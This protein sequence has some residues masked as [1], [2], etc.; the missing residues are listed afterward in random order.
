MSVNINNVHRREHQ[1]LPHL[2][3]EQRVSFIIIGWCWLLWCWV[4][5]ARSGYDVES[6]F[7]ER[8][9]NVEII[10]YYLIVVLV[11]YTAQL[12]VSATSCVASYDCFSGRC[13][14]APTIPWQ[15]LLVLCNGWA[16]IVSFIIIGWCWLLWCSVVLARSCYDVEAGRPHLVQFQFH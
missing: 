10:L 1:L 13:V 4:V 7:I 12:V 5:L 14:A 6:G 3:G 2:M 11:M 9:Y 8:L 15:I 16:N